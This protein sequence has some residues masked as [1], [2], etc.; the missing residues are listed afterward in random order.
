MKVI[1]INGS[2]R[3]S[4]NTATL[5]AEA[6]KGAKSAGAQAE[7][8]HLYDLDFKGCKSCFACKL[9]GGPSYGKCAV[10]DGLQP[11]LRTIE[12]ADALLVGSPVYLGNVTG[13]TRSFLERL[14]YQ[15]L[16][17]MPGMPSL[18]E[19]SMPV[20]LIYTLGA[21]D[22]RIREQGYDQ[23]VAMIDGFT[24]AYLGPVESL[25]VTDTLLFDDFEKF[26]GSMFDP[27]AKQKR[28]REVFPN[29]C[30]KAYAM[31]KRLAGSR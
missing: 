11:V 12:E 1:A 10:Q 17:Y 22:Q 29:D 20:G 27:E 3:K 28:R 26:E 14:V 31:G 13:E 4:G 5:L 23:S 19:K 30:K 9:K 24:Q 6:L 15:Y 21:N 2:P 7:M 25:L 18:C 16:A 8:I